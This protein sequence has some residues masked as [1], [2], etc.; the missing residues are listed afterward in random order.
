MSVTRDSGSDEL[1]PAQMSREPVLLNVYDM[2]KINEYT[3]N[4][5]LGVFHSGE[6][7]CLMLFQSVVSES[8]GVEIYNTE[9]AYGGHQYP[10]TGIFEI[11][12]RDEKELGEQFRFRQ[13]VHIGYTDFTEEDV[14]RIVNELGKEFRGD[15]YHLMNN[16]CNHFS[17]S[18]TK[19]SL[20][21]C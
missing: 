15:R 9:F 6:L 5:G 2:Y 1:L 16:N 10:F 7:N 21:K 18:F 8:L 14:K 3:S 11:T 4:I 13:S 20:V 19:V 17:G 12:P